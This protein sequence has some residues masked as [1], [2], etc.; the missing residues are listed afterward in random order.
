MLHRILIGG[1]WLEGIGI[2]QSG[3]PSAM[4]DVVGREKGAVLAWGGRRPNRGAPACHLQPAPLTG[5]DN[6]SFGRSKGICT[7]SLNHVRHF[8]R[9]QEVGTM[10]IDLPTVGVGDHV[11]FDERKGSSRGPRDQGACAVELCTSA[12]T[13][14]M[15]PV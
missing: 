2:S 6:A 10:T 9:H 5:T 15:L 14:D 4:C 3:N 12:T 1:E 8:E 11:P 7:G 13:T